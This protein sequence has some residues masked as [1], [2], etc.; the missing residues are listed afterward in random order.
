MFFKFSFDIMKNN[1]KKGEDKQILLLNVNIQWTNVHVSCLCV[2]VHSCFETLVGLP[3]RVLFVIDSLPVCM[4]SAHQLLIC[5]CLCVLVSWRMY[6][7]RY[8]CMYVC[9]HIYVYMHVCTYVYTNTSLVDSHDAAYVCTCL[10]YTCTFASHMQTDAQKCT[11]CTLC[12][13]IHTYTSM[14]TSKKAADSHVTYA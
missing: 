8:V 12:T 5:V 13:Y 10:L 4:Y 7:C 11:F 9:I 6:I 14:Q 1:D 2:L 3:M